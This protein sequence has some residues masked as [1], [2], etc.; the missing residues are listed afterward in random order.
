MPKPLLS[1]ARLVGIKGQAFL[2]PLSISQITLLPGP[3]PKKKSRGSWGIWITPGLAHHLR[4]LPKPSSRQ[5]SHSSSF[6]TDTQEPPNY[7][8]GSQLPAPPEKRIGRGS[9]AP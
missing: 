3:P 8:Q 2:V 1:V 6:P 4:S 7:V 5:L 9:W